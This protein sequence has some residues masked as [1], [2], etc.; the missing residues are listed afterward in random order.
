MQH[1]G[2]EACQPAKIDVGTEQEDAAIP[3]MVACVDHRLRS[4]CIRLFDKAFDARYRRSQLLPDTDIAISGFGGGGRD[5]E[6]YQPALLDQRQRGH[7]RGVKGGDVC[8]Q[9]V[10]R[11]HQQWGLGVVHR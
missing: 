9:M 8:Y 7:D 2:R 5:A 10:T 6:R 1:V 11:H 3:R 4:C